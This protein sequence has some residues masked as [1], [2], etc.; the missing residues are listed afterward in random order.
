MYEKNSNNII[1]DIIGLVINS[2]MH[3]ADGYMDIK[4]NNDK[5]IRVINK[6]INKKCFNSKQGKSKI[7]NW[8]FE[9]YS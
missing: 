6:I 1:L 5:K 4:A 8:Y 9:N 7:S 3:T 2:I